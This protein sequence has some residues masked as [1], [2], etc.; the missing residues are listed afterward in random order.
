MRA[1]L[2]VLLASP[3]FADG[4]PRL[5]Q[6]KLEPV[7]S[8]AVSPKLPETRVD[9]QGL[10]W[11]HVGAGKY[12][13]GA[14]A[15][16]ITRAKSDDGFLVQEFAQKPGPHVVHV[17]QA[18]VAFKDGRLTS[19][20]D[21]KGSKLINAKA[22]LQ[23]AIEL[24]VGELEGIKGSWTFGDNLAEFN[25]LRKLGLSAE[26]AALGTWTGKRAVEAGFTKVVF[27]PAR[28]E[29]L[30]KDEPGEHAAMAA[31]FVRPDK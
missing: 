9:R 26:E 30:A 28:L 5:V 15:V 16:W 1:L 8:L 10:E 19:N 21:T 12:E 18:S 29:Q 14:Q 6:L 23:A 31:L 20:L 22:E 3:V 2:V 13:N 17:G 25:R 7:S 27:S 4:G 11:R 24:F